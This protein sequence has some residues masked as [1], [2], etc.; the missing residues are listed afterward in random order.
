MDHQEDLIY[1]KKQGVKVKIEPSYEQLKTGIRTAS[2]VA[3]ATSKG[4]VGPGN[5]HCRRNR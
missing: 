1:K 3:M 4:I 5:D 2:E